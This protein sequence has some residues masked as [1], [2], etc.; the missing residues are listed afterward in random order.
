MYLYLF[1][2]GMYL[3]LLALL[4][5]LVMGMYPALPVLPHASAE[6]SV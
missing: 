2:I 1:V 3:I 6:Q 4:Y 5:L